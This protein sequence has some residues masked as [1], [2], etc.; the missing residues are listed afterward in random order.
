MI[1][2]MQFKIPKNTNTTHW[3]LHSITKMQ[4]Y[5]LSEQRVRRVLKTPKRTEEGVAPNTIAVMQP[6][7]YTAKNQTEIWVMYQNMVGDSG[8]INQDDNLKIPSGKR[9]RII[10]AWRY[11]GISPT[12]QVPEIPEEVWDLLEEELVG[13]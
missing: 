11:P 4:Q 8:A 9:V 6:T 13:L 10:S 3:T 12:G 5:G 2:K 1:I 7:S